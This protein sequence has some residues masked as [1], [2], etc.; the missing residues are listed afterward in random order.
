MPVEVVLDLV[1]EPLVETDD[2]DA[3]AVVDIFGVVVAAD[4]DLLDGRLVVDRAEVLGTAELEL[5]FVEVATEALVVVALSVDE[6]F[7]VEDGLAEDVVARVEDL[8]EAFV[9]LEPEVEAKELEP[10]L[11]ADV[12]TSEEVFEVVA[13]LDTEELDLTELDTVLDED[14]KE[15]VV[16]P[17]EEVVVLLETVDAL[18]EVGAVLEVTLPLELDETLV[19]VPV[20][21]VEETPRVLVVILLDELAD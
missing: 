18:E 4:E 8:L 5:T 1:L 17:A 10:D 3:V 9:E 16:F 13:V 2:L 15:V 14:A 21:V 19:D 20:C 11:V 7:E 12:V 6:A